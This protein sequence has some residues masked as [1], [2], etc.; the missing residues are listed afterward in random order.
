MTGSISKILRLP[1]SAAELAALSTYDQ[2]PTENKKKQ[3]S[4]IFPW[5]IVN[6]ISMIIQSTTSYQNDLLHK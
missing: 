5:L 6:I 4:M 2:V 3:N 1:V